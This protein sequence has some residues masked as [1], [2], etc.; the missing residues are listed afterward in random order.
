MLRRLPREVTQCPSHRLRVMQGV[1]PF[2]VPEV[3]VAVDLDTL[4]IQLGAREI[5]RGQTNDDDGHRASAEHMLEIHLCVSSLRRGQT[6][7]DDDDALY[8]A[9]PS[10]QEVASIAP[11]LEQKA[12]STPAESI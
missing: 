10:D 11:K 6:N 5:R 8:S 4:L 7:D 12:G 2:I 1:R 3:N 9:R